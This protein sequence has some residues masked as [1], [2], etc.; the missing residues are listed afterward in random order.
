MTKLQAKS[1]L[2]IMIMAMGLM[3]VWQG[4][5]IRDLRKQLAEAQADAQAARHEG[6]RAWVNMQV[7]SNPAQTQPA[8]PR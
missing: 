1:V 5:Q 2:L 6:Y 8:G 4:F 3:V 7:A